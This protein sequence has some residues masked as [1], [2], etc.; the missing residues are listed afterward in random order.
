MRPR[1]EPQN[2]RKNRESG[3]CLGETESLPPL[4]VGGK[5]ETYKEIS[6]VSPKQQKHQW[7]R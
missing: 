3:L 7:P 6:C 4:Q 2:G 5:T 1:K